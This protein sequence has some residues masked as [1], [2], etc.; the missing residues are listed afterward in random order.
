MKYIIKESRLD[1]LV[2]NFI[3]SQVGLLES[4]SSPTFGHT[5][6]WY[7]NLNGVMLFEISDTLYHG[8]GL[9][10][11]ESMWNVVKGMFSLSDNDTDKA[12]IKWM[13]NYLGRKEYIEGVYTFENS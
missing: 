5:Y 8:V 6:I 12:F 4:H 13:S 10:V 7:T 11:L 3:T 9:G 2:Q 1:E